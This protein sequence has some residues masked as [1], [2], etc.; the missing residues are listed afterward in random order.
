MLHLTVK[1]LKEKIKDLD[2]DVKVL[3]MRSDGRFQNAVLENIEIDISERNQHGY[4]RSD[5]FTRI[6]H[7][8]HCLLYTSPSPRDS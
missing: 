6:L 3:A 5:L 8:K 7:R 1:E 2:D 4:A